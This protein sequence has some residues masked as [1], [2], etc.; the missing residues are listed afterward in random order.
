MGG[1]VGSLLSLGAGFHP[2]LTGREN[3]FL[4][5]SIYGL[6]K[7]YIQEQM[8][9]IVSFAELERF[10]DFP[11]RTYSSGMFMRLGFSVATHLE[12]D[13]LLLDEVFAV[14][15]EAFQRKCFGKVFEFRARGG[16]ILFVSHSASAVESLCPRVVLLRNGQVEYD[17]E[18]SEAISQYQTLLASDEN[19]A[20]R[21]AGL[22]EWGSREIRVSRIQLEDASGTERQQFLGGEPLVLRLEL[23]TDS[24]IDPPWLALELRDQNGALLSASLQ[25]TAGLGWDRRIGARTLTYAIDELPLADGRFRLAVAVSEQPGGSLY[26]RIDEAAS[27][28][29]HPDRDHSRGKV[30]LDG[31]WNLVG[32]ST[33]AGAAG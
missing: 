16:T 9:E 21:D 26:H 23:I 15:D 8:E 3:I 6:K 12:A 22:R 10:I 24:D 17:G 13:V 29:V 20:E 14:G 11:V 5:G 33:R 25:D 27:F 19:P 32:A 30:R 31:H 4:S 2:D 28:L 7:K 1:S 18:A